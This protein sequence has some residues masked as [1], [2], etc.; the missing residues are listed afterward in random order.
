MKRKI[1]S[2]IVVALLV[3]SAS[4]NYYQYGQ[5]TQANQLAADYTTQV[6][7]LEEKL[8]QMQEAQASLEEELKETK[9]DLRTAKKDLKEATRPLRGD[10]LELVWNPRTGIYEA[11]YMRDLVS[12]AQKAGY[13]PLAGM[14]DEEIDAWMRDNS[15]APTMSTVSKAAEDAMEKGQSQPAQ[16]GQSG[17]T[18]QGE[19]NQGSN[20]DITDDSGFFWRSRFDYPV[21]YKCEYRPQ[22]DDGY[23]KDPAF[24]LLTA[25][26]QEK[27]MRELDYFISTGQFPAPTADSIKSQEESLRKA[28]DAYKGTYQPRYRD[29]FLLLYRDYFQE[30]SAEEQE[31][32]L[33]KNDE[34][35][36][37]YETGERKRPTINWN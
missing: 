33:I 10:D 12:A 30:M 16:N 14:T 8:G 5:W 27:Q 18:N 6:V 35:L 3:F 13:N 1:L 21:E 32:L 17:A 36:D 34:A 26:Q 29:T 19:G 9:S 4:L 22:Y 15:N 24:L 7:G 37:E 20:S 2:V 11:V 23:L 28:C 25:E 31:D